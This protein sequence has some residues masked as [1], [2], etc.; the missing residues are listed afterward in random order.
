MENRV[1]HRTPSP[2]HPLQH[3]YQL[4]DNPYGAQPNPHLDI[5]MGPGRYSPG[6]SLQ[7]MQTAVSGGAIP[8]IHTGHNTD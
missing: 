1:P 2:G 3:G 8:E 6:D 5:P 7:H 4:D